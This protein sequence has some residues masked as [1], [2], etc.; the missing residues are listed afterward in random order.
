MAVVEMWC[1]ETDAPEGNTRPPVLLIHSLAMSTQRDWPEL[2]PRLLEAGHRVLAV[3]LP[4]HGRSV[5]V[6]VERSEPSSIASALAEL[7][8]KED[9]PVDVVG[10]SL[11]SRLA[12]ELPRFA[13]NLRRL[14]LGGLAPFDPL[15]KLDIDALRAA[16]N[17]RQPGDDPI[18]GMM[19]RMVAQE[20]NDPESLLCVLEDLRMEPFRPTASFDIP[21]LFVIGDADRMSAGSAEIAARLPN[22][23]VEH[24]PGD[25]MA[26]LHGP[27]FGDAVL[28]FL[29]AD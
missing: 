22:A 2:K 17:S 11:G 5:P 21:T 25:H 27:A 3:D 7:I 16:V 9:R 28:R 29:D 26:A 23:R 6:I 8:E 1:E 14:V 19:S 4:G 15:E 20:G 18:I 24:V 10:Y 12:W 13:G